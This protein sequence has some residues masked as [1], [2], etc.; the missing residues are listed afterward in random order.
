M[1]GAICD[2]ELDLHECEFCQ[3]RLPN[4]QEVAVKRLSKFSHQGSE[5]F[6]NEVKLTAR[7]QHVNLVP[8][9]G[10]CNEKEEKMLIYEFMPNK[11]LDF[12]I[13]GM[14]STLLFCLSMS[15]YL[16]MLQRIYI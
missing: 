9:L 12:Y 3:G 5:E 4:G 13:F 1:L 7:L 6:K 2:D 15:L 11:S 14:H 8:V 16:Y 10:I